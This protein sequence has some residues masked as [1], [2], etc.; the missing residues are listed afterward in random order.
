ME[1]NITQKTVLTFDEATIY[2][3]I[4]K[5][6]LYKLTSLNEIPFYK[7]NGKMIYFDRLELEAWLKRTRISSKSELENE[8]INSSTLKK[9]RI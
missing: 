2:T 7:P 3:G 8:V 9:F 5:S 4:S 6:Y 1:S